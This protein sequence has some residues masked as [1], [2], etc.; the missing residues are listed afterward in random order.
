MHF[1]VREHGDQSAW[2]EREGDLSLGGIH[3][4]AT[5]PPRAEQVEVRFRLPGVPREI[6]AHA[7]IIRLSEAGKALG[8]H[9]RFTELAVES[10][11][12]IARYIDDQ[13]ATRS[14]RDS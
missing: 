11:L 8:F 3:W 13:V 12:A 14:R 1:L 6:R 10:E 2:E 7:E 5:H 4:L 9:V